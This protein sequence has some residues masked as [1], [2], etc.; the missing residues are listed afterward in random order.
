MNKVL[1]C[2]PR[3]A[4][5]VLIGEAPGAYEAKTGVPFGGPAGQLLNEC[6]ASAGI[7]RSQCRILNV[8]TERPPNNDI[9]KFID[10]SK[11]VPVISPEYVK[12]ENELYEELSRCS[13]N[14]IVPLGETA[15]YATMRLK[16]PTKNRGSI[17]SSVMLNNR[18]VIPTIHPSA[19]LRQ[20][21]YKHM[22]ILDLVRVKEESEFPELRLP[23]RSL[24]LDPSFLEAMTYLSQCPSYGSVLSHTMIAMDIEVL[25][26]EVSHISFAKTPTDAICIPF[27]HGTKNLF[28]PEEEVE[29]WKLITKIVE[30]P[31]CY[32]VL[33]NGIFDASFLFE[34]FGMKIWPIHDTMIAYSMLYPGMPK[35][36]DFICSTTTRE[37]YY[38]DE[39]KQYMK[40]GGNELDF[41]R[42]NALDS[43]VLLEAWPTL[44]QD[45]IDFGIYDSYLEQIRLIRPLM[46]AQAHGIKVDIN[47]LT[48]ARDEAINKIEVLENLLEEQI[49]Y[50]INSNSSKQL[51]EH[52]Y[53]REGIRPYVS[54]TTH[55][56][57][58]DIEALKRL[59]IGTQSRRGRP[60]ASTILAI[61]H[62]KKL[63]STYLDVTLDKDQ[64]MR[65]AYNPVGTR[66]QRISS[67]KTIFGTG[68]NMQNLPPEFKKH[69]SADLG[70][71][72]YSLDIS[73]SHDK[74]IAYVAPEPNLI[75]AFESGKDIHTMTAALL[76]HKNLE[77]I[78]DEPG[79]CSLGN[80]EFSE[81]F[82]GKKTNHALK[83]DMS[84]QAFSMMCEISLQ[85]ASFL[86]RGWN[87]AYP[88]IQDYRNRIISELSKTSILTDC[89]G[90]KRLFLDRWGTSLF[91]EAYAWIPLST[92]AHILNIW[93][94][95]PTYEDSD[96]E[97]LELLNIV[98][99][100][101]EFQIPLSLSWNQHEFMINKIIKNMTQPILYRGREFCMEIDTKIGTTFGNMQKVK[102]D[103][104]NAIG[105][106]EAFNKILED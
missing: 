39:G 99:D 68:G 106:M 36:L 19:A 31:S 90:K 20:Y 92:E 63:K 78:S 38:K 18:K 57:S 97:K 25:R 21:L 6:L 15:L 103:N 64:R 16:F 75:N 44:E 27:V 28:T 34:K 82:W 51:I 8:I 42:Y 35:G 102:Q 104:V 89:F 49:G 48:I 81:R 2:G 94:A 62:W 74:I 41:R 58:V 23:R 45:M 98:H 101:L 17:F 86:V 73:K 14:V 1:G 40:I 5:I 105:L 70:Y 32:K 87:S 37:P 59:A 91:R 4:K 52:F 67:S 85:E 96:L 7:I 13:A 100:S 11:K 26:G 80:G 43:A 95:V 56:P 76:F 93:G 22:I 54:R 79:S 30:E 65:G 33:Q 66:P 69:L 12:F 24:L 83:Y 61:R 71:I 88:G 55:K 10:L 84:I 46:Y 72:L 77:D 3:S 47:G 53:I 29:L 9:K 50:K 60:E